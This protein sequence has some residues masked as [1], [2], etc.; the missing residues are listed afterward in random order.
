VRWSSWPEPPEMEDDWAYGL[1]H[2]MFSLT[3]SRQRQWAHAQ[4]LALGEAAE[5]AQWDPRRVVQALHAHYRSPKARRVV[6]R[7]PPEVR[8]AA[9]AFST[10]W[11]EW[12]LPYSMRT[13]L[14]N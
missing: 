5:R 10:H 3:N 2:Y 6:A 1:Y 11:R 4:W 13:A 14:P 7:F 8:R 9:H 12:R